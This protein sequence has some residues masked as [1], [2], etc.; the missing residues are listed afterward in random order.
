MDVGYALLLNKPKLERI[1]RNAQV[2][3]LVG[4]NSTNIYRIWVPQL[5]RVIATRDVT[6]DEKKVY[7]P[8]YE[9]P[10]L[11]IDLQKVIEL[12]D[13]QGKE[14]KE[15]EEAERTQE[16]SQET[17]TPYKSETTEQ[18]PSQEEQLQEVQHKEQQ[19][20]MEETQL[21]TPEMTP[22]RSEDIVRRNEV[23]HA[24]IA[25]PESKISLHQAFIIGTDFQK[26]KVHRTDLPAAPKFWNQLRN[27]P[28][29]LG[30]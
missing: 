29:R 22:E 1:E 24:T 9:V 15:Y 4:Y 2:G 26:R 7:H 11:E 16:P 21:H 25:H 27:H 12:P 28:H 10:I 6:F 30:F 17:P 8:S 3:Y 19:V 5:K 14:G 23:Y 13:L 18:A 20:E